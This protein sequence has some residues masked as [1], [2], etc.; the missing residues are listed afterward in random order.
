MSRVAELLERAG[1]R[2]F[3]GTQR[4]DFHLLLFVTEGSAEHVVDFTVHSLREGTVLWIRPG[5]THAWGDLSAFDGYVLA[6]PD[7]MFDARVETL[8]QISCPYGPRH[9]TFDT[10]LWERMS[11][12]VRVLSELVADS[13]MD[14]ELRRS[15]TRSALESVL[16]QLRSLADPAEPV[17][18]STPVFLEFWDAVEAHFARRHSVAEYAKL[19]GYSTRTLARA[20]AESV[21]KSPKQVI[22]DRILLEARRLLAHSEL[23]IGRIGAALGFADQSNFGS[24]FTARAGVRPADFR[25]ALRAAA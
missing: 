17:A 9:W 12:Q 7:G 2:E 23:S 14:D 3:V 20:S 16:L 25:R 8:G 5:M 10:A 6:F 13:V 24:W 11:G 15:V 19:L 1:A 22:D 21:G 4:L 18:A